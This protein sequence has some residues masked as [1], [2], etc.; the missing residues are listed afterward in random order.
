[1]QRMSLLNKQNS[2]LRMVPEPEREMMLK[3]KIV[4]LTLGVVMAFSSISAS[5]E[6]ES[7]IESEKSTERISIVSGEMYDELSVICPEI[8][9]YSSGNTLQV[10]LSEIDT[11]SGVNPTT[12]SI[13]KL[14]ARTL[15]CKEFADTFDSAV[16]GYWK[17]DTLATISI[18]NFKDTGDFSSSLRITSVT[19]EDFEEYLTDY[20]DSVFGCFD[21]D[22]QVQ[23]LNY[24]LE[25]SSG[26]NPPEIEKLYAD[27]FLM[28]S[29]FFYDLWAY[30]FT[31]QAL[32]LTLR[33]NY[34]LTAESGARFGENVGRFVSSFSLSYN[35]DLLSFDSFEISCVDDEKSKIA[36]ISFAIENGSLSIIDSYFQ[37]NEFLDA[38]KEEF[39]KYI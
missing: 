12:F 32:G 4:L 15:A 13:V 37:T 30:D 34:N 31:A 35:D 2:K 1:M 11:S 6:S 36:S 23:L 16:I 17:D 18:T 8:L 27:N 5:A 19:D 14:A 20:Y 38:F 9:L 28:H 39:Y 3:K 10:D 33:N 7:P 26:G 29:S 22:Y 24:T 21:L 25:K